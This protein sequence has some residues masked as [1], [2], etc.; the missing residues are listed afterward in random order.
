MTQNSVGGVTHQKV[1]VKTSSPLLRFRH[2]I[3]R[4]NTSPDAPEVFSYPMLLDS[5][6]GFFVAPSDSRPVCDLIDIN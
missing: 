1:L 4:E 5:W 3:S 6:I 2:I